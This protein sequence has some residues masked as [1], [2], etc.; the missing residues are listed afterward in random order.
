MLP[1]LN[2]TLL[3]AKNVC[4]IL[5]STV[6]S[7]QILGEVFICKYDLPALILISAGCVTVVLFSST[8]QTSY[9]AEQV[10][11]FLK[12]ART[13]GFLVFCV[14]FIF[15][16]TILLSFMLRRLRLFEKDCDSY[17]QENKLETTQSRILPPR[18]IV[19]AIK[20][21]I[22]HSKNG[23]SK[24]RD[25]ASLHCDSPHQEDEIEAKAK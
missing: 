19:Q 9:T 13:I 14:L 23:R 15:L 6:L 18:Q 8:T 1:R 11:E 12:S 17:E 22:F 20:G 5:A 4:A 21:A 24:P 3:A 25:V 2:L 10:I 7:I 16:S